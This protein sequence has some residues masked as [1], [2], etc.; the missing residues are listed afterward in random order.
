M[1][2]NAAQPRRDGDKPPT[3]TPLSASV[4]TMSSIA[5]MLVEKLV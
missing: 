3:V 4:V 1:G 2:K 5:M